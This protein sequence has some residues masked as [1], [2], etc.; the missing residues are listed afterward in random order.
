MK[1]KSIAI[2]VLLGLLFKSPVHVFART[3]GESIVQKENA[4]IQVGDNEAIVTFGELGFQETSL[5]SP[6]D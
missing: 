6:F 4:F 5:V 1:I 2:L 3:T